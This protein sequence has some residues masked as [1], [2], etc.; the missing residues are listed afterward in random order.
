VRGAREKKE[1]FIKKNMDL[2]EK[3][4]PFIPEDYFFWCT[5]IKKFFLKFVNAQKNCF[6]FSLT[7]YWEYFTVY[8]INASYF[9]PLKYI[10][11]TFNAKI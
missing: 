6:G 5:L 4:I 3:I 2:C 10:M 11:P 9:N 8:D 7:M 1:T